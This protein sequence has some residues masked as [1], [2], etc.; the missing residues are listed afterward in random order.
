M[1]KASPELLV[2]FIILSLHHSGGNNYR[3]NSSQT[4]FMLASSAPHL[5]I[6]NFKLY[7][8]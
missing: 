6:Q 7:D 1:R 2:T 5:G 8:L 3:F 4:N